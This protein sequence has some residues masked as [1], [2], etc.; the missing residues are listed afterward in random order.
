MSRRLISKYTKDTLQFI[1]QPIFFLLK[2]Q[3]MILF[4]A[5]A[6]TEC[7]FSSAA[8]GLPLY[9][10]QLAEEGGQSGLLG[11]Q[12]SII[13]SVYF[14]MSL[15]TASFFGSFSDR[16]GR[17]PFLIFG[18]AIAGVSFLIFPIM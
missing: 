16:F 5:V 7:A 13:T 1:G 9:M 12:L 18:T 10:G 4:V 15:S 14:I 8:W 2:K 3:S 17:R 6:V 11:V